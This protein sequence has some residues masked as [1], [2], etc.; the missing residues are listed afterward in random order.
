[1]NKERKL[2]VLKRQILCRLF[3]IL[4]VVLFPAYATADIV[5]MSTD[6]GPVVDSRKYTD[7]GLTYRDDAYNPL[8]GNYNAIVIKEYD[9][10]HGTVVTIPDDIDGVPV[11]EIDDRAFFKSDVQNVTEINIGANVQKIGPYALHCWG[12][13]QV[14][15]SEENPVYASDGQFLTE[16]ETG[17]LIWFSWAYANS[18]FDI[19]EPLIFP[20]GITAFDAGLMP[21]DSI[22]RYPLNIWAESIWLPSTL[23]DFGA[24]D[25]AGSGIAGFLTKSYRIDGSNPYY[26]TEDG[27]LYSK[28]MTTLVAYPG[29][30]EKLQFEVPTSVS[31]IAYDA[32][33]N[34]TGVLKYVAL[35]EG[36]T[37]V[38][39]R[40]NAFGDENNA[41]PFPRELITLY[42]RPDS[43]AL[44]WCR[45][46]GFPF[47]QL[48]SEEKDEAAESS[49]EG[50][51]AVTYDFSDGPY[52][53]QW[54]LDATG[55]VPPYRYFFTLN[56]NM[57]HFFTGELS[58]DDPTLTLSN[59][60]HVL[61]IGTYTISFTIE[62]A[63][64]KNVTVEDDNR[65]ALDTNTPNLHLDD[66]T[67]D[68]VMKMMGYEKSPG[69]VSFD[70]DTVIKTFWQ[71]CRP[72]WGWTQYIEYGESRFDFEV[73]FYP[74]EEDL[75]EGAAL[76]AFYHKYDG[77][78]DIPGEGEPVDAFVQALYADVEASLSVA[79][80]YQ[81]KHPHT[82]IRPEAIASFTIGDITRGP[83]PE[84]T[85]RNQRY[86]IAPITFM[87]PDG[88]TITEE[89]ALLVYFYYP[90]IYDNKDNKNALWITTDK[91]ISETVLA[92][93]DGEAKLGGAPMAQ[94]AEGETETDQAASQDGM[95]TITV[96]SESA[97]NV[98]T[99]GSTD[100]EIV[101][102]V[103]P[104]ETF[105]CIG[106]DAS[107]WYEIL[108]PDG[109]SAFISPKMATLAE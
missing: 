80:A 73:E 40:V 58:A 26:K 92:L 23:E 20:E 16:K 17:K 50:P 77:Q 69:S 99:G 55:G 75:P 86:V 9:S 48:A 103:S 1:M 106:Q 95:G 49:S 98:R 90:D 76:D 105:Q 56:S 87:G 38:A 66:L 109:R 22:G 25:E 89:P 41:D 18:L 47:E 72:S 65:T 7:D 59:Y 84:E 81:A 100:H 78:N 4:L 108:L 27:V 52:F 107:G 13:T 70:L 6:D 46:N 44:D 30:T 85:S 12:L 67:P 63:T 11:V 28:D 39:M 61:P 74:P 19:G 60:R 94:P 14:N 43:W 36:L 31:E 33:G 51:L 91:A 82:F 42:V 32:F 5:V 96:T 37:H 97:V 101:S 10:S 57:E 35:P 15:V 62:D 8:T 88:S 93:L 45:D 83:E 71:E 2:I 34:I 64:G 53:A 54:A 21:R 24:S 104:G 79:E 3:A 29:I 102:K 68:Q